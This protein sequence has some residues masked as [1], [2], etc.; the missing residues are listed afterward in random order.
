MSS[1]PLWKRKR[2]LIALLLVAWA[3]APESPRIPVAGAGPRDWHRDTF[4]FEPWGRSGVHK[5]IDVFA[6]RDTPVLAP[7]YGVVIFRG[8]IPLGGRVVAMLGPKWRIHYFAHLQDYEVYPGEPVRVGSKLGGVGDSGNARGK[9]A[10][11]HY[12]VIS[13]L[14]YPWLAD[15]SSQGWKKMFYLDPN[16]VLGVSR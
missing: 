1:K 15:D 8:D 5:G 16:Q 6:K 2:L 12:S 14:P 4:W 3:V 9:P 10:H 7:T 13:L 11:L